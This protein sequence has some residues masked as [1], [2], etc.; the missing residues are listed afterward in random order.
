MKIISDNN[1]IVRLEIWARYAGLM[2]PRQAEKAIKEF[3]VSID[4]EKITVYYN[5][6]KSGVD[7]YYLKFN[8]LWHWTRDAIKGD[9]RYKVCQ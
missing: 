2:K 4:D 6:S 7:Y 1:D 9:A 8:D 5:K 3:D